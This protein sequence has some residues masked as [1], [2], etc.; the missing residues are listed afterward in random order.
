MQETKLIHITK[1]FPCTAQT[2]QLFRLEKANDDYKDVK[3][4]MVFKS[5]NNSFL[6]LSFID[7]ATDLCNL[8]RYPD[9][10]SSTYLL[11]VDNTYELVQVGLF[12]PATNTT[13]IHYFNSIDKAKAYNNP[14][15]YMHI[16]RSANKAM[17]Y[18]AL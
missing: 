4:Y 16:W 8:I 10:V 15:G 11:P 17:Q 7:N 5:V 2:T 6:P 12:N 1:I 14:S 13:T 9:D 18:V 3:R